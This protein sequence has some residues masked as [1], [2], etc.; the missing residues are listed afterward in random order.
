[1]ASAASSCPTF[2]FFFV[3]IFTLTLAVCFKV[4]MILGGGHKD[5]VSLRQMLGGGTG[6]G[7]LG[8][9]LSQALGWP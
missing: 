2:F 8:T 9:V 6:W 1:M 7:V 5:G 4:Q 3:F